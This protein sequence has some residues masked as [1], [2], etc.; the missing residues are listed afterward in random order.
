L[1]LLCRYFAAASLA[2][3][4]GLSFD[5]ARMLVFAAIA[6]LVDA[7]ESTLMTSDGH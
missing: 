4:L 3:P 5:A 2:V 6:A 7:G 1:G